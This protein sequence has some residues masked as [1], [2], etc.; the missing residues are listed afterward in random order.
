M[1]PH[2]FPNEEESFTFSTQRHRTGWRSG[3]CD[4]EDRSSRH[5]YKDMNRHA[6]ERGCKRLLIEIRSVCCRETGLCSASHRKKDRKKSGVNCGDYGGFINAT[7]SSRNSNANS[8]NLIATVIIA[9]RC[10]YCCCCL[11]KNG[12][13]S[14]KIRSATVH[15]L[16]QRAEE[17]TN[18]LWA[19][20]RR[21]KDCAWA[22]LRRSA[23]EVALMA[24]RVRPA[25]SS[26][27]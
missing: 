3:P 9:I 11:I 4:H 18:S 24:Q 20:R 21:A 10:Y 16:Y 23:G 19:Y 12:Q 22:L 7:R 13:R 15:L 14:D 6:Y 26:L 25:A 5:N 27:R 1:I 17:G 8:I 2:R